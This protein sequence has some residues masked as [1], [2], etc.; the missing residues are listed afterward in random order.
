MLIRDALLLSIFPI[1]LLCVAVFFGSSKETPFASTNDNDVYITKIETI[2]SGIETGKIKPNNQQIIE[3]LKSHR[4]SE[5]YRGE[6][7][8]SMRNLFNR[9]TSLMA[10]SGIF[11]LGMVF[12]IHKNNPKKR[13]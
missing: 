9:L 5:K 2:I 11:Q 10:T 7:D 8:E 4:Q 12:L 1:L 3:V 6:Y 13:S